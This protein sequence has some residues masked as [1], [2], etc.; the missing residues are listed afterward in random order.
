MSLTYRELPESEY[1]KL[2]GHPALMGQAIPLGA[3]RIVVAERPDGEIVGF[4]FIVT[5]VHVEPIWVHPDYRGTPVAV[6]LFKMG[7]KLLDAIRVSVAYCFS[8]R[9]II[10]DYLIR[11]GLKELPYRTFLYDPHNVYPK[12]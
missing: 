8:E 11:L 7:C 9:S 5:V 10:S 12:D 1:Y 4:Q 2:E 6:R 3:C